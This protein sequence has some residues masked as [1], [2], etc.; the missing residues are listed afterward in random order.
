[1][2]L[3]TTS[4][5]RAAAG[6]PWLTVALWGLALVAAVAAIVLVLPGTLTAQYSFL[7]NPDSQRGRDLLQQRMDMP[8]KANEV[9]IVRSSGAT[10]ADPAFRAA[11]LGLQRDI[12]ALGPGVVDC[13]VSAFRAETRLAHLRRRPH[14]HHPGRHGR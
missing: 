1:M 11:V 12:A 13:V 3:S 6:R 8:Q 4:L 5:A 7:G 9:V 14:G 2:R 10:A